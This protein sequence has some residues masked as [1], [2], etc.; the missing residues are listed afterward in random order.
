MQMQVDSVSAPHPL[1]RPWSGGTSPGTAPLDLGALGSVLSP[2]APAA[3]GARGPGQTGTQGT[4]N[5]YIDRPG[6]KQGA[7]GQIAQAEQ[8]KE[9]RNKKG[10]EGEGFSA[11]SVRQARLLILAERPLEALDLLKRAPDGAEV[12]YW[13]ARSLEKLGRLDEAISTYREVTS[14]ATAGPLAL[15]AGQDVEFLEW[16]RDFESRRANQ[17]SE[18]AKK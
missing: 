6:L 14:D 17:T 5:G 2:T 8:G 11:D 3:T 9:T 16:K 13:R 7:S 18:G 12:K 1:A 15:R 10:L 4:N